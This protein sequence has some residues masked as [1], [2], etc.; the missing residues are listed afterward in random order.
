MDSQDSLNSKERAQNLRLGEYVH[1][2][3]LS[4]VIYATLWR[5]VN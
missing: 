1:K 5:K 4:L 2:P 3:I